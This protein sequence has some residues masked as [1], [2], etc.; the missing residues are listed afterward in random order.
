M[1]TTDSG[2]Q[3]GVFDSRHRI[4]DLIAGTWSPSAVCDAST[5]LQIRSLAGHLQTSPGDDSRPVSVFFVPGRIEVL[6]KH[7]DYAGGRSLVAAVRQGFL[8][9]AGPREDSFVRLTDVAREASIEFRLDDRSAPGVRDWS[10]YPRTVV[11]RLLADLG[12]PLNGMDMAFASNLPSAAGLS[13]SSAL[14]LGSLLAFVAAHGLSRDPRWQELVEDQASLAAYAAAIE[15][16]RPWGG[17][18]SAQGVGTRGGAQDHTAIL[19]SEPGEVR[20]FRFRPTEMERAIPQPEGWVF[21]VGVSGVK[22]PKIGSALQS[23]NRLADLAGRLEELWRLQG[24]HPSATLGTIADRAPDE[25]ATGLRRWVRDPAER[26]AL[27]QRWQHFHRETTEMVPA[28]ASALLDGDIMQFGHWADLSMELATD[29]LGNQTPE[30]IWLAAAARD[31]GAAAASSFGAGFG[32]AVWALV[33]ESD[34]GD[35]IERWSAGYASRF[36][37]RPAARFFWTGAGGPAIG[38]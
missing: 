14:I 15:S 10:I 35:F 21:A 30:T 19:C 28:A 11:K 24:G 38:L 34:V 31:H 37:P 18:A 13:S 3:A 32:G 36:G 8:I 22:A 25:L 12:R 23:Y 5:M 26:L 2:R 17:F 29:L 6:G 1:A 16:G 20:Q 7:T 27:E 4:G 9:V 33:R